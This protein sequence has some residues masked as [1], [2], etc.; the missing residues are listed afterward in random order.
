MIKKRVNGEIRMKIWV[1]I[2]KE[3][4]GNQEPFS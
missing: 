2:G 3:K 1:K 4:R